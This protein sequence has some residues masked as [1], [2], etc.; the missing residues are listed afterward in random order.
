MR[1][2][3]NDMQHDYVFVTHVYIV[4]QNYFGSLILKILFKKKNIF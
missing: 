2:H 3:L 4:S 1:C